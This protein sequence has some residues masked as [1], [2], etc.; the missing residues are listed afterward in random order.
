MK[1]NRLAAA[2]L[3]WGFMLLPTTSAAAQGR[4]AQQSCHYV[5]EQT[6]S[7]TQVECDD[8]MGYLVDDLIVSTYDTSTPL[9]ITTPQ[10][11]WLVFRPTPGSGSTVA[12]GWWD[13][14]T[15]HICALS[16]ANDLASMTC[17]E[18][19]WPAGG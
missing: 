19:E 13:I 12:V 4:P 11:S 3:L 14:Q 6:P 2:L 17:G 8:N 7:H 9:A 10:A 18:V 16:E 1:M 5:G 15:Q